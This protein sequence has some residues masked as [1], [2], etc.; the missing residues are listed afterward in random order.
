[1]LGYT[2]DAIGNRSQI[3]IN[4]IP[5][6]YDRNTVNEYT[7]ITGVSQDPSYDNDVNLTS[8]GGVT[9]SWD[10]ENRLIK[11]N[12]SSGNKIYYTYDYMGRRCR[13]T[14]KASNDSTIVSDGKYIY[15]GWNVI[16]EY[17]LSGSTLTRQKVH[18]WGPDISGSLQGA[19]GVGG[20]VATK[21]EVGTTGTYYTGYDPNG[22]VTEMFNSS[23]ANVAHY[24]YDAF[25]KT[26][27]S[28]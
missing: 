5:R 23:G 6:T 1:T 8:A 18:Y 24:E 4:G 2:F 16:A 27:N 14:V 7:E 28:A 21:L 22:N 15:E 10:G 11:V 17:N 9:Y 13:K 19:G 25:G 3:T 26:I 20:L 12:I